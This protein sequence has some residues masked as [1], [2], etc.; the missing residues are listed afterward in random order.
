MLA[1]MHVEAGVCTNQLGVG[2]CRRGRRALDG[3]AGPGHA[4]GASKSAVAQWT[5]RQSRRPLQSHGITLSPTGAPARPGRRPLTFSTSLPESAWNA[6]PT[7]C[8]F[9]LN[10]GPPLLPPLICSEE[11]GAARGW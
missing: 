3:G 9:P 7:H 11:R 5:P 6:M 8:P 1:V 4:R 10:T 2:H